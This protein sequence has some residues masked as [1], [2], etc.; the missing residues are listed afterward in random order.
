V[1]VNEPKF[2]HEREAGDTYEP[3]DFTITPEI[4]Q[5]FLFALEDF[6]PQYVGG[7]G[8]GTALVHPVLLLHMSART[9]SPS[10]RLAPDSGSIFA[11]EH[12]E[13]LN[14]ARVGQKLR[15]TWR[16]AETYEKRGRLYHR[17]T[18][19]IDADDGTPILRREMHDTVFFRD[20]AVAS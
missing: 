10:F 3:L 4:N 2:A 9:R 11:R 19:T 6:D 8:A 5:Q 17:I 18:I 16:I 15:T 14:P 7:D 20:E 1:N 13:F 12:V